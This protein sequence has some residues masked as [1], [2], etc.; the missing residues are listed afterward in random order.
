MMTDDE[1]SRVT[2]AEISQL[3]SAGRALTPQSPLGEQIAYFELKA[4]LLSRIAAETDTAD[5]REAAAEAW[6]QVAALTTRLRLKVQGDSDQ[7]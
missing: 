1:P 6:D 2:P 4:Q 7:P 3:L 5:A